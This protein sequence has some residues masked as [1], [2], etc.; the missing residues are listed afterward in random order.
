MAYKIKSRG[1]G[2]PKVKYKVRSIKGITPKGFN[3]N[4]YKIVNGKIIFQKKKKK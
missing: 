3:P 1:K 4:N 2:R